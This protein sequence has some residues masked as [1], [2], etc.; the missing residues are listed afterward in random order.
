MTDKTQRLQQITLWLTKLALLTSGGKMPVT[1]QQIGLY[2][3]IFSDE[4]PI[5]AFSDASLTAIVG[6]CEFFPAYAVLKTALVSWWEAQAASRL[7][8][9]EHSAS[10]QEYLD[11]QDGN[12]AHKTRAAAKAERVKADWSDPAKVRAS[13]ANLENAGPAFRSSLGRMLGLLVRLH[14]PENLG[15]VPPEFHPVKEAVR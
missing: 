10:F 8:A 1:K 12:D 13:V 7:P 3:T 14:A 6:G 9:V 15:H 4:V 11:E 5:G 2:A